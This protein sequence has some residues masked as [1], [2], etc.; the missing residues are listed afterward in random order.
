MATEAPGAAP[1]GALVEGLDYTLDAQGL[2]VFTE[3]HNRARGW[4]CFLACRHCPWGQAGRSRAE[5]F[6]DLQ[7]RLDALEQRL[8]AAGLPV[9][10][11]GYRNGVLAAGPPDAACLSDLPAAART[12]LREARGLLTVVAVDWHA[13][14]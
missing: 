14:R 6:A 7:R 1:G 13:P 11:R 4:C 9:E 10:L 3:H 12:V 5:A 8:A 2:W